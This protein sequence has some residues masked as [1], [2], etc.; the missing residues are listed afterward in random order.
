MSLNV[1]L[2]LGLTLAAQTNPS[3]R[4]PATIEALRDV[5]VGRGPH[6]RTR[7]TIFGDDSGEFV[8]KKG[9]RFQMVA[10]YSEGEC[11]IRFQKMER[12]IS[13][14]YWLEGFADQEP[15]V[16]RVVS[17]HIRTGR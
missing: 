5:T 13:S 10:I 4:L 3:W 12:D 14:C 6:E 2:V 7:L 9:E 15:D 8:I 16:F 11:R 1:A 17:G